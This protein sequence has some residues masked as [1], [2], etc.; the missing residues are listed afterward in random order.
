MLRLHQIINTR[1]IGMVISLYRSHHPSSLT[2]SSWKD[3]AISTVSTSR[4]DVMSTVY[5]LK[6]TGESVDPWREPGVIVFT[7]E[8]K[9]PHVGQPFF[10]AERF[11]SRWWR[12]NLF[13]WWT[14]FMSLWIFCSQP[15]CKNPLDRVRQPVAPL[16]FRSHQNIDP[17]VI[18]W[19][20]AT[21]GL[22]K[23]V[24]IL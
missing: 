3:L 15:Y 10:S 18:S 22:R 23:K 5:K 11:I 19:S 14:F 8:S 1:F 2:S 13:S 16:S 17:G 12:K 4:L 24:I 21:K 7:S 9:V 6:R 20:V